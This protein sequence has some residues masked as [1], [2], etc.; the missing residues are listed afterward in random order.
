[1]SNHAMPRKGWKRAARGTMLGTAAVGVLLLSGSTPTVAV[2]PSGQGRRQGRRTGWWWLLAHRF[3]WRGVRIWQRFLLR[4]P[5]EYAPQLPG[6]GD[7]LCTGREGVLV[8]R[9]G[10]RRVPFRL[11]QALRLPARLEYP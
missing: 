1:M 9:Q 10:R 3:R 7:R 2:A 4:E 5:D 6:C 11:R 8:G